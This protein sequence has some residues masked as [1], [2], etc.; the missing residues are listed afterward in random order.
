LNIPEACSATL[1]EL[2]ATTNSPTN[3]AVPTGKRKL[4]PY[5]QNDP[6][7]TLGGTA[8][9][10]HAPGG[11][12]VNVAPQYFEFARM[13]S[14]RTAHGSRTWWTRSQ[15]AVMAYTDGRAGERLVRTGQP[16]EYVVLLDDPSASITIEWGGNRATAHGRSVVVVPPGDSVVE[17]GSTAAVTR[18]FTSQSDDLCALCTNN[19][20]YDTADPNVPSFQPWPDAP[21]GHRIR[22]YNI[23]SVADEPGRFGRIFRCSTFMV[24]YLPHVD[25]PRDPK[26]MSPH[27]HDDF[28]Q[29][30]LQLHGDYTHHIRT[31]WTPDMTTWR[32]DE[33]VTCTSPALC[34][35]PPPSIHTSQ[36]VG[37]SR[38][39]LIDIF[40]PPRFDFSAKPGWVLN[41][42]EYPAPAE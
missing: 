42:D 30:S 38:N 17:L 29:L 16:D 4:M 12:G 15:A 21:S 14:D 19:D 11:S 10:T 37:T 31:P 34:V 18:V 23:D 7:A 8:T 33:H 20:F 13:D 35:I 1:A 32:E 39:Q 24:N 6:R 22:V 3:P 5:D 26:K 2:G 9:A 25:G 40:S 36:A 28:E 41:A 27:F